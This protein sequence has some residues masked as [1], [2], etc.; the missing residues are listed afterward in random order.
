MCDRNF[1]QLGR[2]ICAEAYRPQ[3]AI[4][5]GQSIHRRRWYKLHQDSFEFSMSS[6]DT[7]EAH[8]IVEVHMNSGET[9]TAR[10]LSTLDLEGVRSFLEVSLR[11]WT[12]SCNMNDLTFSLKTGA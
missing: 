9:E 7:S 12:A 8:V 3:I 2:Q 6:S 4:L 5:G 11:F 1:F 10:V